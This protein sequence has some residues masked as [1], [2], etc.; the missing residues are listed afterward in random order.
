MNSALV[1]G[2]GSPQGIGAALCRRFVQERYQTFAVGRTAEKLSQTQDS[3]PVKGELLQALVADCTQEA[4]VAKVFAEVESASGSPPSLIVYNAGN[5]YPAEFPH[6]LSSEQFERDW[7]VCAFGAQLVARE[8]VL[9]TIPAGGGTLIFTGAT[10]SI[11]SKPPFL[12]FAS[13][14][15]ALRAIALGLARQ[16]SKEGLHVVHVILDG[17]VNGDQVHQ[18]FPQATKMLGEDGMLNVDQIADTLWQLH[19][20]DRTVWTTELDIR[21]FKENF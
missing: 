15:A 7:R 2:V 18:R 4:D 12:S 14:K 9:R 13:A 16:F 6:E 1:F 11:R 21:P 20:Q 17:V 8:V 3:I 19:Q 10:A 5:N